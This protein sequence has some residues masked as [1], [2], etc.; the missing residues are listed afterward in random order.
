MYYFIEAH[1][2]HFH[3]A[4]MCRV[5]EVSE[6]A[7]HSWRRR[8]TSKHHQ[9]DVLL[10]QHI[11]T[12]HQRSK[13]RYGAPRIHADLQAV[14]LRV[15]RKRVARLMQT[16]GLRAKGS[17]RF[18]RTTQSDASLPVC[19]NL[20]NRE[21]DVQQPNTVFASDITYIPTRDGWLYL[22]VTLDL[23]SRSVVG[24]AMDTQMP[25]TLPLDALQMAVAA[26]RPPPGL[27]HH[28]DR[29][30]QYASR[31]FQAELRQIGAQGSM[32]RKGD[33][34]DNAVLESF[35]SSLKRELLDGQ[36]FKSRTVARRE[37]FEYIEVFYNRQRRHSS[38]DYLTPLEF[39]R[40]AEAA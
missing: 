13:G 22:A 1:R 32:S 37:I 30:G 18:V 23:Y 26:R 27:I 25:T 12:A 20:L 3:L 35:F 2:P 34:W 10:Q 36:V 38:L 31:R 40:Q 21:F 6:S 15:S 24:Y 29:G 7:Y 8:P 5:L 11:R 9:Q 17:R 16:C 19:P 4:V 28:S 39:E 33:C 14:G